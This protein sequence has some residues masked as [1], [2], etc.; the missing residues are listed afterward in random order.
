MGHVGRKF[1]AQLFPML[2][3]GNI[4]NDKQHAVK[5]FILVHRL[6]RQ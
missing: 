2:L 4:I 5:F 3:L 1:A 6:Y